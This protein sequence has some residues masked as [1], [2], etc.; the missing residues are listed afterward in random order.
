MANLNLRKNLAQA[1]SFT[2]MDDNFEYLES[3][4]ESL[5]SSL[6]TR[7]SSEEASRASGDGSLTT[8]LDN[9]ANDFATD[10][11]LSDAVSVEKLRAETAEGVIEGNLSTELLDRAAADTTLQGNIDDVAG[12]LAQEIVDRAADVSAEE[13]RAIAAE[14]DLLADIVA[15]ETRA[16]AAE[17]SLSTRAGD[18]EGDVTALSTEV[19][20]EVSSI[21][22]VLAALD[23]TYVDDAE[24]SA[25]VSVEKLRAE[26]AEGVIEGNLSTELLDRAAADTTLQNNIDGVVGDLAQELL[27]RAAADTTLQNNI[28]G[29]AG[30][31]AQ[32]IVDRAADV[33][34][35]VSV[36]KLRAE[37]AEGVLQGNIDGVAGDLSTEISDREADVSA[38][39]SRAIAAEGS[40][41]TRAGDIESDVTDLSTEVVNEVS[42]I[43]TVLAALDATYVDDAELSAAVSVEKLRA[44][45][46]EGVIEGNL[47]TELLDRAAADT[48]LSTRATGIEGN[49]STELVDRASADTSLSTRATGIE[50][51]VTSL[52]GDVTSIDTRATGIEGDVTSID[53]RATGIEGDVTSIDTRAT[54]IEGDVTSLEGDV[55]SIDTRAT[56]IEGDVTSLE[57]DVTSIN[58]RATGIEGDVT[59]LSTEVVNEVSSIDTVLAALDATYVDDAELS[60]A[61]SVEKLR[62][63]TAEGVIEGNLSTELLD[64]AAADT[65]LQG[66]IDDVVVDLSTELLDRAAADTALQN[67]IDGVVGDLAQELLDRAAADTSLS[68]RA[69]GIEGDV[70]DL[71]TEVVNEVSSI[72]TVLA[73]LDATYVDDAELSAAVS[74][75]KL[76]AE[77]AEGV[78]EDNLSTELVDRASADTSLSTRAGD[79]E[80]DVTALEGDL[81]TE[82]VD[83]A[84]ADTS[85]ETLTNN[86]TMILDGGKYDV[87]LAND[88]FVNAPAIIVVNA[89][90]EP[91]VT[92]DMASAVGGSISTFIVADLAGDNTSGSELVI[93]FN[94]LSGSPYGGNQ[95]ILQEGESAQVYMLGTGIGVVLA[96]NKA[97]SYVTEYPSDGL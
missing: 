69:T 60:A 88:S 15:E 68:T 55:T 76:R 13:S 35:S 87:T 70:T 37:T 30:D 86:P 16:L 83:R 90:A 1:L 5:E 20:N 94:R 6:E 3:I 73:T 21:D 22:T 12:D 40:L 97:V 2:Q 43:D 41:S 9:L 11:E 72:D 10:V 85:L 96:I 93:D 45:T 82:L 27:D 89:P 80:G 91:S 78:I 81:S 53:T 62:A 71:S 44:E 51:D 33:D 77:T 24:L 46:A 79:I 25:A 75:E 4:N 36:E 29:V 28:D 39:E 17:G 32:E 57:G 59:D 61:V 66:K 26:T 47:S 34:A 58:T 50:G 14:G 54:G 23:A 42:S 18:I 56:G 64:R 49:L 7:V 67:N 63:E 74:V 52:E 19:V 84:A 92:I 31:L 65:A 8:R 95:L 48:S 38:E